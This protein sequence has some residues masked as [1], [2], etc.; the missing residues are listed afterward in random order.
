MKFKYENPISSRS[1]IKATVHKDGKLGFS[2][3]AAEFMELVSNRYI[4]VATN[5]E[6]STDD[7]LYLVLSDAEESGVFKV[8]KAGKYYYLR[9]KHILDRYKMDYKEEKIIFDIEENKEEDM[10]YYT[11]KKRK[12]IRQG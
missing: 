12:P 1:V 8:N 7:N 6:D 11:L 2:T 3:G 4:K 10:I 5:A 9:I